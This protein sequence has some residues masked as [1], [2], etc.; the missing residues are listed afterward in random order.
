MGIKGLKVFGDVD[1]IIQQ[2]KKT[3][4]PKHPR[5]KAY[6]EELWKLKGS[7]N[8]LNIS[9]IRRMKNE[10]VDSLVVCAST[11]IPPLSPK[12]TYEVQVKYRLSL[13]NNVKY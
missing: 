1:L 11:F 13:P 12:L 7:F 8:S 9:Y 5:M 2:V 10:L 4:Q 3:F 6:R